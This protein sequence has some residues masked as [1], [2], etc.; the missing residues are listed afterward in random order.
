MQPRWFYHML[1]QLAPALLAEWIERTAIIHHS[2]GFGKEHAECLALIL[3]LNK[4]GG[5]HDH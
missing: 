5:Y 2:A 1:D 3:I 4:I